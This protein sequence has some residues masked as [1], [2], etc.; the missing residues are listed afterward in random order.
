M[1]K[2]VTVLPTATVTKVTLREMLTLNLVAVH[3]DSNENEAGDTLHEV[4]ATD[5]ITGRFWFWFETTDS[6]KTLMDDAL[7]NVASSNIHNL[8]DTIRMVADGMH[9]TVSDWSGS[10]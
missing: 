6:L 10:M 5:P 8:P 7:G 2:T 3:L 1:S 4:H 9:F